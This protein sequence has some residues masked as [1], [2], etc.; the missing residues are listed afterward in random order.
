[1]EIKPPTTDLYTAISRSV[2]TTAQNNLPNS[3]PP[4][5]KVS[6][7]IQAIIT[8][9]TDK[10]LF[11][12]IQGVKANTLKPANLDLQ[13]GDT[14]KLQIEQL[15]PMPQ[16]RIIHVQQ[17]TNINLTSQAVRNITSQNTAIT[18][19]LKNLSFIAN[20]PALRPSPLSAGTNA[21]VR[22]IF[23]QLP[24]VFNLKTATQIKNHL[25][26]SGLFIESKIKN[27]ILSSIQ[28]MQV[29]KISIDKVKVNIKPLLELDLGAQLHRLADLIRTQISTT[30]QLATSKNTTNQPQPPLTPAGKNKLVVKQAGGAPAEQASLQ[31]ISQREEAMQTFLRQI[32]SSLT[33]MQQTQ[34]QNLSESQTGR[35]L[36]LMELPIKNGQDIDLFELR[37]SEEENTQAEGEAKKIWNVTLKFDLSGLGKVKAHIKMQNEL[38]SAQFYSEKTETLTLFRENFDFLRGR[39]NYNGL[40]VGNI[41][42]AHAKLSEDITPVNSSPLDEN[43]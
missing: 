30:T 43:S 22:N 9:I 4:D 5:W 31:N 20:R 2:S 15:K 37:I 6:Q 1:M 24:S 19:M 25:Q 26:N 29:N 11:L 21:A 32:E 27:Q 14:L 41:E 23:K 7:L 13:V 8:K 12:D 38:I 28:S 18:P 39:L 3:P 16:F 35:P 42:C 33:H 40:N 34:L 10:Q 36:W 17:T